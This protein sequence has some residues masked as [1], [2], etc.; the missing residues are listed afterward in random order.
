MISQPGGAVDCVEPLMDKELR[1]GRVEVVASTPAR[2]HVRWTYQST[3]LHYQV[4]GDQAVEDYFFYPDGFG[5]RVLKL[6]TAPGAEYELSEFIVLTPQ[7]TYP[8]DVLPEKLVDALSLD[9]KKT[10]YRFPFLPDKDGDPRKAY[11]TPAIYRLRPGKQ[12]PQ[13][14]VFFT[15]GETKPPAVV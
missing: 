12:E 6:K 9:G 5:T 2:V 3:D 8:F 4:W 11:T 1:Y 7:G 10:A 13:S 15:P 14:A